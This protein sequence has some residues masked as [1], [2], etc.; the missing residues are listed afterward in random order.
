MK[1]TYYFSHDY[2]ARNDEKILKMIQ[3]Y[4]W[5]SY[6]L[7]WAII[8]KL[9]ES[10]GFLEK[11]YDCIAFD[12][13]TDSER[14]ANVIESGL[15]EFRN[16]K[17]YSKSVNARLIAR[18]GK[19]EMARQSAFLRWNKTKKED[20]NA[21]RTQ[22]ERYAIKER[23]GKERK[24]QLERGDKSPT[25]KEITIS[26][27]NNLEE[28]LEILEYLKEK[29]INEQIAKNELNK[30]IL[31]WTEPDGS[32]RKQR[33]EKEK[34]FEIKRRLTTWFGKINNQNN[35]NKQPTI[36]NLDLL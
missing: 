10:G 14:I 17:F 1:D 19:S 7:F 3:K 31:Y 24:G 11:D 36:I 9:Y 16:E 20:A 18:K 26:F 13:R 29:G 30:F 33:W 15:F 28:Q 22:C 34:V 4:G 12:L 32:G 8:E 27:F 23:K 2:N 6:G 25:P 5:E 35:Y 21:M